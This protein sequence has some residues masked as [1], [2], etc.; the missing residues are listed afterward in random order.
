MPE[1]ESNPKQSQTCPLCGSP[2]DESGHS[3]TRCDW[4]RTQP[5]TVETAFNVRDLIAAIISVVPGAGHIFKGHVFAGVVCLLG[6]AI[7]FLMAYTYLAYFGPLLIPAY[8]IFV[9]VIAYFIEDR[10][11]PETKS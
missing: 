10:R 11:Y 5:G 6:T 4:T 7:V 2:L 1:P 9:M 8:W 3:C